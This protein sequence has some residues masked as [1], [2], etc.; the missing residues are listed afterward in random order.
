[1]TLPQGYLPYMFK[2][3]EF[4]E[5]T[6]SHRL[7]E[8]YA[9]MTLQDEY[10]FAKGNLI[11]VIPSEFELQRASIIRKEDCPVCNYNNW[12]KRQLEE[13]EVE[14]DESLDIDEIPKKHKDDTAQR[15]DE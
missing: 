8:H 9:L 10:D 15:G 12:L 1:M 7:H 11:H 3:I 4:V 2:S 6:R 14:M 13:N 5:R